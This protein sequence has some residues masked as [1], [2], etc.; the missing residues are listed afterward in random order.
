LFYGTIALFLVV[1]SG[2]VLRQILCIG[3]IL[4]RSQADAVHSLAVRLVEAIRSGG[5]A[6]L[7]ALYGFRLVP[8][9]FRL[10]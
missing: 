4:K 9:K 5:V 1:F 3:R 8:F 7:C 10:L 2:H 6:T